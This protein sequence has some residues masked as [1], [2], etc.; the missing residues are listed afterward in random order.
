MVS[1]LESIHEVYDSVNYNI[2]INEDEPEK[3]ISD[4]QGKLARLEKMNKDLRAKNEELKKNNI[5]N[6][7]IMQR[8][9]K[10]GLRRKFTS[11]GTFNKTQ[12]DPVKL[13]ELSKQKEDLQE[14][15]EK[16]LD[17][18]T[19]KEMEIED[20]QQKFDNYKAENE[21]NLEKIQSLEDKID[22]LEKQKGGTIYDIDEV[23]NEYDKSK[24]KLKQQ[25]ND[26]TKIE[27]DLKSQLEM[28][29][30]NIEK[31]NEEIQRLEIDKLKLIN[32]NTRKDQK[33]KEKDVFEIEKLK[34]ELEKLQRELTFA[35]DKLKVEQN[36]ASQLSETYKK[37]AE[38]LQKKIEEEQNNSNNVREEKLKEINLLKEEIT[39]IKK[40]L[41][42][43][44]RK[45]DAAERRLDDEKQ[46]TF[47][48]QNKLDKKTKELNELNECTKKLLTN[49]DNLI[50]E[51][52]EKI[53]E[54]TKIKNDLIT[55]NK[56]LLENM[57]GNNENGEPTQTQSTEEQSSDENNNINIE[58]YKHENKLLTEEINNLKE[59]IEIQAKDLIDLNSFEKE[60]VKLRA[61]N[62]SLEKE[63]KSMRLKLAFNKDRK[64]SDEDNTIRIPRKR[65]KTQMDHKGG[66]K[67]ISGQKLGYDEQM[68]QINFEKQLNA[69]KKIKNE[70]KKNYEEKIEKMDLEIANLK[71]KYL[72]LE[73]K[74]EEL[75]LKYKNMIKSIVNQCSK[76]GIK[77]NL[78]KY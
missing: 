6:D 41:T 29:D 33:L 9:N 44:T 66:T 26:Y 69:L 53:E 12:N 64:E 31:L 58:Q 45:A 68:N 50:S 23:V 11:T 35:N 48:A 63:N 78:D 15:N 47:M 20:L 43:Y 7:S 5:E 24:E 4:L 54:I 8:M 57:K 38:N 39:K 32:Q 13:A 73:Y 16:M 60:I 42:L 17:L 74:N 28:K 25:I 10:V 21:K 46:K 61:Q 77:L 40:D 62:E 37:E 3:I 71:F 1:K 34:T 59:Q 55:Q 75:N 67:K 76:K 49:K 2:D 51:Y 14:M 70:E 52:E 27:K 36:K 72:N 30:R 22:L 19:E 18:L 65:G 56:Q